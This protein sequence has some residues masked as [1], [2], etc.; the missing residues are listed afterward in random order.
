M[1]KWYTDE[2]NNFWSCKEETQ[3]RR[4]SGGQKLEKK[5]ENQFV[6][7]TGKFPESFS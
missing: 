7:R 3:R 5:I 6:A 1:E 2:R 4:V